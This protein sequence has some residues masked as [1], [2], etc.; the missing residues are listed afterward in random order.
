MK[1]PDLDTFT[2]LLA[3]YP[4]VIVDI[5]R[6]IPTASTIPYPDTY[7][8][9]LQQFAPFRQFHT[10]YAVFDTMRIRHAIK[11]YFFLSSDSDQRG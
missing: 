3:D 2:V 8:F 11:R 4:P 5:L 9:H 1:H 6:Y 7:A 10:T